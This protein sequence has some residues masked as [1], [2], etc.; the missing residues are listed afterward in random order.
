MAIVDNGE[1]L[2]SLSVHVG[3]LIDKAM[4]MKVFV[5]SLKPDVNEEGSITLPHQMK[6]RKH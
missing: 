1:A 5:I 3:L 4:R 2:H 6:E